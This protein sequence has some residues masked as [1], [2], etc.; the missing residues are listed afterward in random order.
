MKTNDR[1]NVLH[2]HAESLIN[3]VVPSREIRGDALLNLRR[4]LDI[5]VRSLVEQFNLKNV[6]IQD[7]PK[8]SLELLAYFE[9]VRPI[10]AQN[11]IEMRNEV[12]HEDEEPPTISRLKE[13]YE[14]LWYFLRSTEV[15]I[16]ASGS[17]SFDSPYLEDKP[18]EDNTAPPYRIIVD[19]Q[20][21]SKNPWEA[22]IQGFFPTCA[23]SEEQKD[24]YMI[25][26]IYSIETRKERKLNKN[27]LW[28]EEKAQIASDEDMYIIG[29]LRGKS[30]HIKKLVQRYILNT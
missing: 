20:P 27:R 19:I 22:T 24:E 28:W 29:K 23:L 21:S 15:Q 4:I 17:L 30:A 1:V 16:K 5:R 12:E 9:I 11:L 13:L 25:I 26:D 2:K 3:Q 6:P 10:M 18:K 14:F 8:G 7:K